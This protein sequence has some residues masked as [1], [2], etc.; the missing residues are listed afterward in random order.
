MD[1]YIFDNGGAYKS[2]YQYI[3][4]MDYKIGCEVGVWRAESLIELVQLCPNIESMFGVDNWKPYV[5]YKYQENG[6]SF[7][8][9]DIVLSK[10]LANHYIKY[11]GV[12][13]KI[14]LI[15]NDSHLACEKFE[16]GYFDF[17]LLDCYNNE[18]EVEREISQWIKKVK[19]N[20]ILAGHDFSTISVKQ[21]LINYCKSNNVELEISGYDNLWVIK[22]ANV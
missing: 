1:N 21:G 15:E 22:N 19:P 11:S 16:D 5:D 20:G 8:E 6:E 18:V 3:T 12:S 13:E 4:L 7:S 9:K 17:V 10:L 2:I 14:T